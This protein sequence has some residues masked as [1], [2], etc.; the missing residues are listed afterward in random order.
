MRKNHFPCSFLKK[1]HRR[2]LSLKQWELREC[3]PKAPL[4]VFLLLSCG[5]GPAQGRN[6]QIAQ[7]PEGFASSFA[8][9]RGQACSS[10]A[11]VQLKLFLIWKGAR[12]N[13][14]CL[15]LGCSHRSKLERSARGSCF[16][17]LCFSE[18]PEASRAGLWFTAFLEK[19]LLGS[20]GWYFER[21]GEPGWLPA[22]YQSC[23]KNVAF[24]ERWDLL[25]WQWGSC[26]VRLKKSRFFHLRCSALVWK[27][28]ESGCI[29]SFLFFLWG[30]SFLFS[31]FFC[32]TFIEN[33]MQIGPQIWQNYFIIITKSRCLCC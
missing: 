8:A 27:H 20:Q 1:R 31:F 21:S 30:F 24:G 22:V 9:K 15:G 18:I 6:D 5:E 10:S 26:T 4:Y 13:C 12:Q 19:W 2:S 11:A 16:A 29:F 23:Q 14:P 3:A 28:R 33:A 25:L 7:I 32:F 17:I